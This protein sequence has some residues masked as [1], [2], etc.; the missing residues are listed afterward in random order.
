[1]FRREL[2]QSQPFVEL[3]GAL[4]AEQTLQFA[5]LTL[6]GLAPP[7]LDDALSFPPSVRRLVASKID[8]FLAIIREDVTGPKGLHF[9]WVCVYP[10]SESPRSHVVGAC[11]VLCL[12]ADN[13]NPDKRFAVC[14]DSK[15]RDAWI[16]ILRSVGRQHTCAESR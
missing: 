12:L 2:Q 11:V 6:Q 16:A 3:P 4:L 8:L 5:H 1:M 15:D 7:V 10:V 9:H 13:P 14:E